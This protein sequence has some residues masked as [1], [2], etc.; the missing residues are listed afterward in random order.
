MTVLFLDFDGVLHPTNS[1]K[2]NLFIHRHQFEKVLRSVP[3]IDIVISSSWRLHYEFD[4]LLQM[5]S[6]DIAARIVGVTP[7]FALLDDS[8]VPDSLLGY[9][10]EAECSAWI[11]AN[12]P[13]SEQWFAIDD[14][15][16]IFRPFSQ[17]LF[18]CDGEIGLTQ[19]LATS[20][21]ERLQEMES[22]L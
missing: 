15:P 10:R 14:M 20:L 19:K 17:R 9:P 11:R 13:P 8:E 16:W 1:Y 12:R 2:S 3:Q 18:E 7:R 5:F 22:P 4:Y 6:Q 21:H